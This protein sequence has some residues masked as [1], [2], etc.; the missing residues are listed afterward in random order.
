[1]KVSGTRKIVLLDGLMLPCPPRV[2]FSF[3][4]YNVY[5]FVAYSSFTNIFHPPPIGVEEARKA[6]K[7]LL[8]NDF[9]FDIVFTSVLTRAIQTYNYAADELKCHY[10]PVYKH[11]RLNERHYGAL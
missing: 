1:V 7:T 4:T 10:L 2:R 11:W 5:S 6:G 8:Q 3:I 9:K